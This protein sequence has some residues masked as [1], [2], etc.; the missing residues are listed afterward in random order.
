[1]NIHGCL[2]YFKFDSIKPPGTAP[3]WYIGAK[4]FIVITKPIT[5]FSF[6]PQALTNTL[7]YIGDRYVSGQLKQP[8]QC[9]LFSPSR[10]SHSSGRPL[11]KR[12]HN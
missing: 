7:L 5:V 6:R 2:N 8:Q 12:A 9:F 10:L 1:M 4:R 11:L 3:L